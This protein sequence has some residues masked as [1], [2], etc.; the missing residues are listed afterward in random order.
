MKRVLIL[1]LFVLVV[2]CNEVV[3]PFGTFSEED[4]E[5]I[6]GAADSDMTAADKKAAEAAAK[7]AADST[8]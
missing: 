4:F 7:Q 2:G 3:D 5:R 8:D 6:H 1:L